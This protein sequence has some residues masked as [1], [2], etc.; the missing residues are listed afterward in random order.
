VGRSANIVSKEK[1]YIA[2][3]PVKASC[4]MDL[5]PAFKTLVFED[6]LVDV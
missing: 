3:C 1:T 5:L 4:V 6:A 2:K